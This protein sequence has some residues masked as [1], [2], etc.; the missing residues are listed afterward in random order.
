MKTLLF[1]IALFY[2]G[3]SYAQTQIDTSYILSNLEKYEINVIQAKGNSKALVHL[4][5]I[6]PTEINAS[7]VINPIRIGSIFYKCDLNHFN[8]ELTLNPQFF[9]QTSLCEKLG[10]KPYYEI[11]ALIGFTIYRQN[12]DGSERGVATTLGIAPVIMSTLLGPLGVL[13]VGGTLGFAFG[14]LGLQIDKS[15]HN[16]RRKPA[17]DSIGTLESNLTNSVSVNKFG[18]KVIQDTI[19]DLT[20]FLNNLETQEIKNMNPSFREECNIEL[21]GK[22]FST[23]QDFRDCVNEKASEYMSS[24]TLEEETLNQ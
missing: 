17:V 10:R 18:N 14:S 20:N 4:F 5:F 19:W 2:S 12:P 7:E 13:L 11:S 22:L 6:M 8:V 24:W 23:P 1:A 21:S 9:L 16:I 3:L 15:Y